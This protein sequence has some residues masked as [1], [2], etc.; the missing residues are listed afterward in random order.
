MAFKDAE[1]KALRADQLREHDTATLEAELAT[2]KEALFRLQFRAATEALQ[3]DE[4][5]RF[6]VLRR[7]IAR[8]MTVL[9]ERKQ[10]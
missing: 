10:Q 3:G 1:T 2:L 7:N 6:Q 9:R 5:A 4:T 8:T